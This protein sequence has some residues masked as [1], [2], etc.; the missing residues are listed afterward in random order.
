MNPTPTI[1]PVETLRTLRKAIVNYMGNNTPMS[2]EECDEIACVLRDMEHLIEKLGD[3]R[4]KALMEGESVVV[5]MEPTDA[6]KKAGLAESKIMNDEFDR[7]GW[8]AE[9]D[10]FR[11]YRAMISAA[12]DKA[13][14]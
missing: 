7:L 5:P 9:I 11:P 3:A 8:A 13:N 2:L 12:Q 4:L 6:M 1:P 10:R 14:G